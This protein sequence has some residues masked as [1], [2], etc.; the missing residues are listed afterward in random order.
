MDNKKK[1]SFRYSDEEMDIIKR[2]FAENEDLLKSMRKVILQMPLDAKD[3]SAL[4]VNLIGNKSAMGVVRKTFVPELDGNA[5][6]GQQIDLFLTIGL[7]DMMPDVAAIHLESIKKWRDYLD[8]QLNVMESGEYGKTQAIKFKDFEEF[9]KK[10]NTD[11]YI[12]MLARNTI[13]NS[14]DQQLMQLLVLAGRK[15]DT[16]EKTKEKLEWEKKN[17]NK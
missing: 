11:I 15:E 16:V 7:K 9:G 1:Q 5:P 13:V 3:L 17:S 14:T 2:T 8:Q 4:Q 12:D 10:L 6:L